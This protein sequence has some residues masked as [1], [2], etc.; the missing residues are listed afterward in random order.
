[1]SDTDVRQGRKRKNFV[2][3]ELG[4]RFDLRQSRSD[5]DAAV[6]RRVRAQ[7]PRSLLELAL[8]ADAVPAAGLVPGDRDVDEALEEVA[9]LVRRRAPR[10]FENLVSREELTG[11]DQV[12]AARELLRERP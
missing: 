5:V 4:G 2:S 12:E 9:L 11:A 7:P 8:A 10:V 1:V 3:N 6:L